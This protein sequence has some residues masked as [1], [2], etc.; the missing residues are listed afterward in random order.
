MTTKTTPIRDVIRETL[1]NVEDESVRRALAE[2]GRSAEMSEG[3]KYMLRR[4]DDFPSPLVAFLSGVGVHAQSRA[5]VDKLVAS[6]W[7]Q[8][9]RV[10]R[11]SA[12]PEMVIG[13]GPNALIYAAIRAA[14]GQRVVIVERNKRAGGAFACSNKPSFWLNSRNRPGTLGL[15]GEGMGLNYLFGCML[16]PSMIGGGEF[17][18]NADLA[19]VIR[20][21]LLML[22]NVE[23]HTGVEVTQLQFFGRG[24][25]A[26]FRVTM[27]GN[28]GDTKTIRVSRIVFATGL[29]DANTFYKDDKPKRML[30]FAEFM[31]KMDDPFPLQGMRRVAVIGG[32][33]SAKTVIEALIGQGPSHGM[34]VA[35]I[36]TPDQIDWFGAA[37]NNQLEWCNNNRGRYSRIGKFLGNKITVRPRT[38]YFPTSGYECAYVGARTYDWVINCTGFTE[39]SLVKQNGDLPDVMI[40]SRAVARRVAV[41]GYND[42]EV[43]RIGPAAKLPYSAVETIYGTTGMSRIP[44]NVAS[45]FRYAPLTAAFADNLPVLA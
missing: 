17:Q 21:N 34:S 19:W 1:E 36:D 35:E 9:W 41:S 14:K 29:G 40:G 27:K 5:H 22:P 45:L 24:A 32:G 13:S 33:D 43:Y 15:P 31:A 28:I 37:Y 23:V 20:M 8:K 39:S 12:L 3:V 38:D 25:T 18:T 16:Q 42:D 44:E 10:D 2:I 6:M 30:D 11:E 26:R 7:N 4:A